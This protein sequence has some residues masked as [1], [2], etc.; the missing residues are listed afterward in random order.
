MNDKFFKALVSSSLILTGLCVWAAPIQQS[1]IPAAPYW[2]LHLDCDKVRPTSIGQFLLSELEK[3]EAQNK[4][5]AFT[6]IFNFDPRKQLHGLT[7]YSAGD[8]PDEA[9]LL[10]YADVDPARL[11]TL[12]KGTQDYRNVPYKQFVIHNWKDDKK[13]SKRGAERRVYAAVYGNKIVA[14][15]QKES[16]VAS[17]LDVLSRQAPGLDSVKLWPFPANQTDF[18]QAFARKM[19]M[20]ENDPSAAIFKLSKMVRLQVGESAGNAKAIL[21]LSA[22]NEEI[23]SHLTSIANGLVA[24]MKFQK[25]KPENARIAEAMSLKQDSADLVVNLTLPVGSVIEMFKAD[26]ARKAAASN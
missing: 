6:A 12:A 11:E 5:A 13:P 2:V 9:V 18:L 24:L 20:A 10:V 21:T 25:G 4:F 15:G 19:E 14:F 1:D 26:A 3:P 7:L 23:A 17:A 8:K 16:Q 22:D